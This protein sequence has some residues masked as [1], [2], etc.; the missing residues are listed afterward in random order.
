MTDERRSAINKIINLNKPKLSG[1]QN[2][3][4][5]L[6]IAPEEVEEAIKLSHTNKAP[7]KD[8]LIYE[9]W[10]LWKRPSADDKDKDPDV[11]LMLT[12]VFNDIQNFG[13]EDKSFNEGLMFLLYKKKEKTKI[14]NYRPITLLNTDYK[15]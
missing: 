13:M 3:D 5:G 12:K 4:I 6:L 11:P 15:I 14:E 9:L 2:T 1:T 10:K 8:G 7:G